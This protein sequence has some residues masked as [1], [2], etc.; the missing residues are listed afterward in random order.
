MMIVRL[1]D[2]PKGVL[3]LLLGKGENFIE[4]GYL[5]AKKQ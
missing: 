5:K 4:N 3:A 1:I 2:Y